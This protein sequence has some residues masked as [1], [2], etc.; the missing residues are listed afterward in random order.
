[1]YAVGTVLKSEACGA[2]GF[3]EQFVRVTKHVGDSKMF[4]RRLQTVVN[5]QTISKCGYNGNVKKHTYRVPTNVLVPG[6]KPIE[7][8]PSSIGERWAS[9]YGK[10]WVWWYP[11][12]Y[13]IHTTRVVHTKHQVVAGKRILRALWKRVQKKQQENALAPGGSTAR[14]AIARA[15]RTSLR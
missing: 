6:G 2:S 3:Q 9:K 5:R 15:T 1:M 7:L 13:P 8:V 11:E 10:K 14:A 4:A 12:W